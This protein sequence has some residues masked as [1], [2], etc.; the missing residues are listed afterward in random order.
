M[1]EGAFT[2][3]ELLTRHADN[4][5]KITVGYGNKAC[6]P[7]N[8]REERVDGMRILRDVSVPMRDGVK[9]YADV[10]LPADAAD[11]AELGV[12]VCWAAFGKHATNSKLPEAMNVAPGLIS[13]HTGWEAPDPAYWTQHGYAVIYPD[14]RGTWN[15]EGI[16]Y[17]FGDVER[18][19]MYDLCEWAGV[20][21]WSNGKVGYIGVSYPGVV[22]WQIAGLQPPHLAAI[23]PWEAWSDGY[24]EFAYHGGMRETGHTALIDQVMRWPNKTAED[25]NANFDAHPFDDGFWKFKNPD[26][27][28]VQVP[29]LVGASWSD[30]GLHTKGTI[31]A[32]RNIASKDKWLRVHG[33]KKWEQYYAPENVEL[34]RAFFDRFLLGREDRFTDQP[35]ITIE[36]RESAYVGE[37]REER[38]WPLA[39]TAWTPM[40]LDT[41]A[42]TLVGEKPATAGDAR[43]AADG[44]T[45]LTF[46]HKFA[47]DTEVTG[48]MKLKL[49]VEADGS[50]DMDLFV[51][52]QKLDKAGDPVGFPFFATH[53]DGPVALGWLRASHREL[54]PERSTEAEP[55]HRHQSEQ[56]LVPGEIVP[57]EIGVW[58]SSTLFR[59]GETLR[60]VIKGKDIYRY[61]DDPASN[62]HL[63]TRNAGTHIVHSGG[64][65][66]SHILLPII[67]KA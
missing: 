15:N 35:L 34:Q 51:A 31:N 56:R 13:D 12:I 11:D 26:I 24:R 38:E 21:S 1:S 47:Q 4:G 2:T 16:Y 49:W 59:A 3:A 52:V 17:N 33:R 8:P 50:D 5:P 57:V 27:K 60:V 58:P 7:P 55:F 42:R 61:L 25:M 67:P 48:P 66:D 23:I 32:W 30:Q 29:A 10:Y 54:D 44:D 40:Y 39:R 18:S 28:S 45:P 65:Y 9:L 53:V 6:D 20:Q 36:V 63:K 46:D 37:T 22:C 19:D 64:E 62:S 43:Y 41:A 14:P